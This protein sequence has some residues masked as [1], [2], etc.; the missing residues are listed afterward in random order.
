MLLT[1]DCP[2]FL[3]ANNKIC[4]EMG[5]PSLQSPYR[6]STG[7]PGD[8]NRF[9]PV[10]KSTKGKPCFHYRD[11]VCKC[12]I[13]ALFLFQKFLQVKSSSNVQPTKS[14][15]LLKKQKKLSLYKSNNTNILEKNFFTN[16]SVRKQKLKCDTIIA[17]FH[18]VQSQ[19][20]SE[21]FF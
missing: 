13:A 10:G 1:N 6:A 14:K 3:F 7:F 21:M 17:I 16:S 12:N 8:G 2:H 5:L 15:V 18:I 11:A 20:Y 4:R 9:F 19:L